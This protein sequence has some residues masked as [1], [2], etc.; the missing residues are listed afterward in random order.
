MFTI[1][2]SETGR[3]CSANMALTSEPT[4]TIPQGTAHTYRP[5]ECLTLISRLRSQQGI[6]PLIQLQIWSPVSAM[7]HAAR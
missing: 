6:V 4:G 1:H 3:A 2:C 5:R 7:C